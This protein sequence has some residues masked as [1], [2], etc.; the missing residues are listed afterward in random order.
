LFV[1][2][3][4]LKMFRP[5]IKVLDCTIRDGGLCN[6]H[7]F[8][9]DFVRR[10][11]QALKNAGVD[12]ME[13]GYKSSKDQFS[14]DKFGPWKFCD[15]KD[16]E[17]VAE[18]CSLKISVMGDVGRFSPADVK[19]RSESLVNTY[20]IAC[21]IKDVDK[22]LKLTEELKAKGYETFI[23]IMAISH[24]LEPEL[25]EALSQIENAKYVDGIYIVDSFGYLYSEQI[26][27][28]SE[29]YIST[30]KSKKVGIHTHNNLQLAFS[31][32][33]E[34]IIKGVNYLDGTI[35][36]MGRGAGNCT[37]E[38]LLSFL[39]NPKFNLRPILDII[40]SD[41]IDMMAKYRWGYQIPYMITGSLNKHP[42][43]A[44]AV[45]DSKN[46]KNFTEFYEARIAEEDLV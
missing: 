8:S 16:I 6:N 35:Y 2:K 37:T 1:K 5:E 42:R 33:I 12:Y 36:G 15:D 34:G 4:R 30:C 26:H 10:V 28:L 44:I 29:K 25:D 43:S 31:N 22:A 27:Y 45:M 20:R 38:L 17:Q 39:K 21:Y 24:A 18:D 9:H 7:K 32:T 19:P 14:P 41:F 40:S 46:W 23:N 13:I 3:A 11:F